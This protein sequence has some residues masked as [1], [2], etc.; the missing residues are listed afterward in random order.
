MT[1]F[2]KVIAAAC[3]V[4]PGWIWALILSGV[5]AYGAVRSPQIREE[6]REEIRAQH[7]IDIAVAKDK[8]AGQNDSATKETIVTETVIETQYRDR[9]KEVIRYVPTP[10]TVCPA[11]PDF[12]RLFNGADR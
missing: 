11:D 1:A 5:I 8:Q 6:G 2:F 10:G 7:R 3:S 12:V 4:V 9:I